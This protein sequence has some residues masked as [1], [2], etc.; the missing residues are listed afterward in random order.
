MDS[1]NYYMR[2]VRPFKRYSLRALINKSKGMNM[3]MST[4]V[5]IIF[6]RTN[7][8]ISF[9]SRINIPNSKFT[10]SQTFASIPK[11]LYKELEKGMNVLY[12]WPTILMECMCQWQVYYN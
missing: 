8:F 5:I 10:H 6:L 3:T 1:L 7:V 2:T 12:L 9:L 11:D 4:A